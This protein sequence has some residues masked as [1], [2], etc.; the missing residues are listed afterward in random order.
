M[1]KGDIVLV[2]F[3]FT[4]LSGNKNRPALVLV[5]NESDITVVF[6]ST[7]IHWKEESDILLHPSQ[8]KKWKSEMLKGLTTVFGPDKKK[9]NPLE[10]IVQMERK[11]GQL[12]IE[13]DFL[14]KNWEG[15]SLKKG[16]EGLTPVTR[17]CR[18]A[19]NVFF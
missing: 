11:I 6:I 9:N 14:R 7:Q 16:E 8:I 13:N 5:N 1:K 12:V 17:L 3:P 19:N 2:P 4:D 10:D 18:F 15:S